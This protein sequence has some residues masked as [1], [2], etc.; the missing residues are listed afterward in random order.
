M[1]LG[2]EKEARGH[3]GAAGTTG[4]GFAET[5]A[6][7]S[8]TRETAGELPIDTGRTRLGLP[9]GAGSSLFSGDG[10]ALS[11]ESPLFFADAAVAAD[12]LRFLCK[13]DS[14]AR[15]T[16]AAGTY[17]KYYHQIIYSCKHHKA[18]SALA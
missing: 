6:A 9:T 18:V 16:M 2:R 5:P 1:A 8:V 15:L 11:S 17:E 12:A 10:V 13:A 4:E 7:S 14:V 3:N